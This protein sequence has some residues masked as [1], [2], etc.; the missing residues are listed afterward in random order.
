[1]KIDVYDTYA[2]SKDGHVI[3]F[4]VLVAQGTDADVAYG[5]AKAWLN[6]IG[7]NG[8]SLEQN[9]CRFCHSENAHPEIEKTVNGQGYFIL[10]MEGCPSPMV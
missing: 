6:S 7:E 4:D 8:E 5:Y 1:M 2:K 9:R 10:Q 3:H